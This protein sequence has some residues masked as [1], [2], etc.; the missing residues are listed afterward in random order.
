MKLI[1][2]KKL[3]QI[4]EGDSYAV[5]KISEAEFILYVKKEIP[6]IF[7]A[8]VTQKDHEKFADILELITATCEVLGMDWSECYRLKSSKRWEQGKYNCFVAKKIDAPD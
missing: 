1:R 2:D 6:E 5:K 4:P 3:Q 7:T 8:A